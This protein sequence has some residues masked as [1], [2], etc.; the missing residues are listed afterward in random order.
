[1]KIENNKLMSNILSLMIILFIW[2]LTAIVFKNPI[3]PPISKIILNLIISI[4]KQMG[5]HIIYSL[6]RIVL[7]ILAAFTLGLPIGILTG[8]F[9]PLD[10]R[11]TPFIY[12]GYP[13]PK[14]TLLPIV[15]L[16]FGLNDLNK[17]VMIFLITVFPVIVNIRDEVK[18]IPQEIYYPVHSIG[19]TNFQILKEIVLPGIVPTILTT[20]KIGIGTAISVLFFTES[21][22][23]TYG[24]GYFIM[25]SYMRIK[26]VDMYSGIVVLSFIGLF[27]FIVIDLVEKRMCRWK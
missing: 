15:M 1:M 22:G 17:I 27:L 9:K 16:I 7:G 13:I 12:I 6:K 20:M 5:L 2:E 25:D 8:Y 18:K 10:K 3:F 4:D 23:T 24:M 14:M 11:L 21:F 26:Y 19:A